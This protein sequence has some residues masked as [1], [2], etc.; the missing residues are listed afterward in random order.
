M[1]ANR[2][3]LD[4]AYRTRTCLVD[5]TDWVERVRHLPGTRPAK[6]RRARRAVWCGD[7]EADAIVEHVLARLA[8]ELADDRDR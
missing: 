6:V 8:L 5:L 1:V 2:M 7:Y 4:R 3:E